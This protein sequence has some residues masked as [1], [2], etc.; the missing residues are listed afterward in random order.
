M[1]L[2]LCVRLCVCMCVGVYV[3]VCRCVCVCVYVGVY[4]CMYVCSLHRGGMAK[5]ERYSFTQQL[6]FIIFSLI[7]EFQGQSTALRHSR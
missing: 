6:P 3:C 2:C 7:L 4:V 5:R 1:L